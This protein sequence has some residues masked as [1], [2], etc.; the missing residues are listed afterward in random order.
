MKLPLS[1]LKKYIPVSMTAEH[2]A[3]KLTLSGSK[4]ESLENI[5]GE[6]VIDI[7]VTTNRPDCLSI[8]GLAYEVSA[9]TGKKVIVPAAYR[10][11]GKTLKNKTAKISISIQDKK[12]CSRYTARIIENVSVKASPIEV[13]KFMSYMG[14]RAVSNVVDATNYVLFEC[15]QPLHAFDLDKIR[16][17]QIIVRFSKNGEKFQG[18]DGIEYALDDKTLVI[19][20]QERPI[21]IAGVMGGK[22]T[23]VTHDTKNI[24]L[25]SAYFD[26][27]LVR[28]AAKKYKI[29]TESSYRFERGVDPTFLSRASQ[30]A[31]D[32]MIEWGGG[33][34]VSGLI[35][36]NFMATEKRSDITLRLD[37]MEALLGVKIPA[38]R[39]SQILKSLSLTV[40]PVGKDKL[41]VS[42]TS[43]R[44]DL[45]QE[46]DLI[47]EVLRIDGFDKI[48]VKLPQS[49]HGLVDLRNRKA[50]RTR[51]L[52]KWMAALGFQEI[53]SYSLL[54]EKVLQ[55]T[56]IAPENC[57]KVANAVSAEQAFFRPSLMPGLLQ[58][59]LFNASRKATGLRLFEIG[60]VYEKN[61][62]RTVLSFVL[63]G[64]W[65]E[66][67]RR[68]SEASL[69]E[70]KGVAENVLEYLGET[71]PDI[72]IESISSQILKKW[73]IG[74]PVYYCELTLDTI[75]KDKAKVTK[76]RPVP[77]Y[78]S[79]KRDIAVVLE[80]S[81]T[82]RDLMDAMQQAAAPHLRSVTLFDEFMGK[83]I[84]QGK[85]SLAF[86]LNYQK[87]DGTFTDPEIQ[88]LQDQV[89]EVLKGRF[90]A[91]F[92]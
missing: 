55:N 84:P 65:E 64:M 15:G 26:L 33:T 52:K 11:A 44:R 88:K 32:L 36:K 40:K 48:P 43:S 46:A 7:E 58:A 72:K 69:Y 49:R 87:D 13:Q 12:A 74:H 31:A 10:G 79:V 42:R 20:D 4:V 78:P 9:I 14:T 19:A 73:D 6:P 1:W 25:E 8:L 81:H 16:G 92:R 54:S 62:E 47:E 45:A 86:S 51:E 66:N 22:L 39:A 38:S 71:A 61:Q 82:V 21:A 70:A 24:L 3:D 80:S 23:E 34:D 77:K 68:K 91:E 29:T 83:G 37:R 76:I 18:I 41:K 75:L 56:S 2:L 89:G 17:G 59:I 57:H 85:R 28:Q 35:D 5:G 30:R 27:A 90:H 67:W 60:N 50:L 63:Y 53:M